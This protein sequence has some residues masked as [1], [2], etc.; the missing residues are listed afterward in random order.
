M[1]RCCFSGVEVKACLM[2]NEVIQRFT[3]VGVYIL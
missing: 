1:S 2:G 3:V